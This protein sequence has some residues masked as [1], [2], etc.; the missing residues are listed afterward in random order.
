M[1]LR[2]ILVVLSLLAFLSV[3]IAGYIYYS[4]LKESAFNEAEKDTAVQAEKTKDSLSFFL[5]E[6]RKTVKALAGLSEMGRSLAN[7]GKDSLARANAVLDLFRDSLNADVCYLMDRNGTTL[8]SS[9]RNAADSF[10][11]KNFSF[12]PYWR[13]SI[14]GEPSTYMAL[15]VTSNV[16]GVYSS[17]PVYAG[18]GDSPIGVVVIKV[19]IARIEE[20][21]RQPFQGIVLLADPNGIIFASNRKEWL[22]RSLRRLSREEAE[23]V[24]RTQ[25]F[26]PGPWKWAG[27]E[28]GEGNKAVDESGRNYLLYR[29][30]VDAYPGWNVIYLRDVLEISKRISGPLVDVT[31]SIILMLCLLIGVSVVFIYK[32]ASDDI[33][34][35]REAEDALHGAKEE[36]SRYSRDL[37]RQVDE[38]TR[39]ITGVLRNTP[40]V[41][42]IKDRS[43]CYTYVNSRYEQ[44]FG[45]R[46]DEIRGMTDHDI[47]PEEFANRFRANDR[48]V[49]TDRSPCQIEENVPHKDGMHIYLSTKFPLYNKEG[50]VASLCGISI[51]ITE[52]KKAQDQMKRLSD[53]ILAGQEKE[54]AAVSRELHDELG[55]VLTALRLDSAWLRERLKKSDPGAS[56]RTEAMCDLIDKAIEEVRGMATRLRPGVLDDLGLVDALDWYI[57]DFEKRSRMSCVF[58][59][60]DVPKV[61]DRVATAAYRIAQEA[62]TNVA[63]HS[64]ASRVDVSLRAEGGHLTLSVEDD[65][66]GFDQRELSESRGLGVVG[67]R[68]RAELI[69]GTLEIR[70]RPGEGTRVHLKVPVDGAGEVLH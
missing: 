49:L 51:D 39:E 38:R 34:K 26:G 36:L 1:K 30:K 37:E 68:E 66:R 48:R 67:M 13:Q 22:S 21:F 61:I 4:S 47:F 53:S 12:R 8:A 58:R 40:A 52:I 35:R 9:N 69:G 18:S 2:I 54:R 16:R 43:G 20:E 11:G 60:F 63:R 56:L 55:Q 32:R 45:V 27:I 25:Q 24:A 10:V 65:G 3:S 64:K 23:L 6:N 7:P 57:D 59:H 46:N 44:L 19:P 62:L 31:G 33:V 29:M 28:F 42:Y 41:V 17:H 15:G 50:D 14:R 70:S 5:S